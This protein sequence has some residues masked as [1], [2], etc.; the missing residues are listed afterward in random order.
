MLVGMH[1]VL[2]DSGDVNTAFCIYSVILR[3]YFHILSLS[4]SISYRQQPVKRG[5]D[6]PL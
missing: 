1:G 3:K 2:K 4:S 6:I 5:T